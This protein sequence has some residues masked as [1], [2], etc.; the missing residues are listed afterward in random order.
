MATKRREKKGTPPPSL[1]CMREQTGLD[2]LCCGRRAAVVVERVDGAAFS[3][4]ALCAQ[5]LLADSRFTRLC[6]SPLPR[7]RDPCPH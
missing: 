3:V 2:D 6:P 1:T 5:E 4:C 7:F